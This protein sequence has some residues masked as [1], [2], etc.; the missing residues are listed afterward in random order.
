MFD[1]LSDPVKRSSPHPL[2]NLNRPFLLDYAGDGN[3]TF[4]IRR[5]KI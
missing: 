1:L 4:H 2:V 3:I 5:Q